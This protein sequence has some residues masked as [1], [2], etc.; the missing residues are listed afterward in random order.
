MK[1]KQFKPFLGDEE[2]LSIKECFDSNWIT[3][4][5]K[6]KEFCDK[7]LELT[8]AKYGVFANNGTLSLY[9]GLKALGI[10]DGDEVL[11]PNFT[12]IASANAVIMA[13]G[14]P[15]FVDVNKDT[16]HIDLEQCRKLITPKTKA[17]MPVHIYGTAA[18]M[19]S[20][21][22]FAN[23]FKLLVIEDAAQAIGVN[24]NGQHCGTFG[25]VG[26]FSFFADK[27][28]TTGE[29]GFLVTNDEK[30]YENLLYLRNQG[31][32]NRG[33][34]IHPEIGFNFRITDIQAAIGL[35][36]LKKLNLIIEKKKN[37]LQLYKKHL[38]GVRGIRIFE[39]PNLSDHVP[40]RV[41]IM[42]EK[43]AKEVMKFF[44]SKEIETRTF[45][46]P[47][48]KQPCFTEVMM[49]QYCDVCVETFGI[50]CKMS[51]FENSQELYDHGVCVPSY[52]ELSEEE[53]RYIC[54]QIRELTN[55]E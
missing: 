31:R 37:I 20:I 30:I 12:F 42:F 46:Y 51:C 27:T 47:L 9:L 26:S 16:M 6:S 41:A 35:V 17:I 13:G 54:D 49:S 23:K 3:E 19:E 10:Q 33:S 39:P 36:Q 18:D 14:K 1:I 28:I 25:H 24:W 15:I 38:E 40:F 43:K 11:V 55:E 50:N 44:E 2:Y 48:H 29:G 52:P 22:E 34:F 8:G 53:V 21:M 7:L 4:G 32:I 45:F 5:P